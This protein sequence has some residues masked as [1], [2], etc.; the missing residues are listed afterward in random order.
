M[1]MTDDAGAD[2]APAPCHF[3]LHE[4]LQADTIPLGRLAL[5][6]LLLMN[7]ATYPWLILVP[8]RPDV[9]EIIE[10]AA[11]D[12]IALMEEITDVSRALTAMVHPDKLNVAAIGNLVPQ[13]HVHIVARFRSDPA[14]P[15]P[16]WGR[17]PPRPYSP[18]AAAEMRAR[19]RQH[20]P[21][22]LPP[23]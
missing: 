13:L 15:A 16:V 23:G 5:S 19:L 1:A 2:G 22:A 11:A 8:E 14:W 20:L 10:L 9:R 7:D 18:A 4:R 12:R 6:R 21:S 17:T 3:A